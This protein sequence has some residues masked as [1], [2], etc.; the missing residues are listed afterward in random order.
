M[1]RVWIRDGLVEV[2]HACCLDAAA[3]VD[4]FSQISVAGRG[5][6]Q[7]GEPRRYYAVHKP[8]GYVSATRDAAFPTVLDLLPP[9]LHPGLHLVGRLDKAST[10]LVILTND[11]RWS[12]QLMASQAVVEKV[13]EVGLETA[14]ACPVEQARLVEA[15]RCGL[16]LHGEST[17][18]LP[19]GLS[20]LSPVTV[21]VCLTEGR[22]HQIKKMWRSLGNRVVSLHRSQIGSY[23]LDTD[24][25]AGSWR[26]LLPQAVVNR[27]PVGSA[28]PF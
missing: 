4:R 1:A 22:H 26:E 10:G 3:E 8:A 25:N 14:V 17:P 15:F 12:S 2:D 23:K 9:E 18:T 21:R 28:D 20:W 24:L 19:A 27:E 5:L 16:H 6:I 11:G 7:A 13:Y